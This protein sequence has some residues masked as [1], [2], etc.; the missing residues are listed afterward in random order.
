MA[1]LSYREAHKQARKEV[2]GLLI[3]SDDLDEEVQKLVHDE[4]MQM[5]KQSHGL[6]DDISEEAISVCRSRMLAQKLL[7]LQLT[8][9][10]SLK[11][12]GVLKDSEAQVL[13]ADVNRA[14]FKCQHEMQHFFERQQQGK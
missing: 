1:V 3:G 2:P 13:K 6:I 11:E 14:I 8:E 5:C 9:I 10:S 12:R 7:R 4:S